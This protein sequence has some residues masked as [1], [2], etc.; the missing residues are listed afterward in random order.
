MMN[1]PQIEQHAVAST[2]TSEVDFSLDTQSSEWFPSDASNQSANTRSLNQSHNTSGS[3]NMSQLQ[4]EALLYDLGHMSDPFLRSWAHRP[5]NEPMNMD[6]PQDI[7]SDAVPI[8]QPYQGR[9]DLSIS[10]NLSLP[11]SFDYNSLYNDPGSNPIDLEQDQ[12][13][14][15]S[16][17]HPGNHME[18]F[19]P[20]TFHPDAMPSVPDLPVNFGPA[21][22][23]AFGSNTLAQSMIASRIDQ[24]TY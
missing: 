22:A 21:A 18:D 2:P 14:F 6:L 15:V 12:R 24:V 17:G 20:V 10:G 13:T 9:Q 1:R 19:G 4:S 5:G 3:S 8:V 16:W 7:R 11:S 23:L